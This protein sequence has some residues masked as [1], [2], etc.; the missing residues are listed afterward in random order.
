MSSPYHHYYGDDI[1]IEKFPQ[2]E[3]LPHSHHVFFQIPMI[4]FLEYFS[5]KNEG[6]IL[7][8]AMEGSREI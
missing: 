5:C 8:I 4:L 6:K 3:N 7:R 2:P 1:D